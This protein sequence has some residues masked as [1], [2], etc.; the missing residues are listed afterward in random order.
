MSIPPSALAHHL[1]VLDAGDEEIMGLSDEMRRALFAVTE[2]ARRAEEAASTA[3]AERVAE[4]TG[5][6]DSEL[7]HPTALD[8]AAILTEDIEAARERE[9][10]DLSGIPL[11]D[12]EMLTFDIEGADPVD[13]ESAAQI[14]GAIEA[15]LFAMK[16]LYRS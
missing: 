14:D 8:L 15:L 2:A 7:D 13:E 1:S 4:L 16:E 3:R 12:L 10:E 5:D 9:D 11:G 6:L